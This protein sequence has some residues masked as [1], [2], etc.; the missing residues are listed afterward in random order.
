MNTFQDLQLL[1]DANAIIQN[2]NCVDNTTCDALKSLTT[3]NGLYRQIHYL[4]DKQTPFRVLWLQYD[5]TDDKDKNVITPLDFTN[6]VEGPSKT[7]VQSYINTN[8]IKW[9]KTVPNEYSLM[10]TTQNANI[11]QKLQNTLPIIKKL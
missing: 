10:Y 2:Y 5:T 3:G 8:P 9:I 6:R 4:I 7:L 1:V 11:G